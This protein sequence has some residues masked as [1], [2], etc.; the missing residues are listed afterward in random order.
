MK[1]TRK[2]KIIWHTAWVYIR[3]PNIFFYTCFKFLNIERER[4]GEK[5]KKGKREEKGEGKKKKKM[6]R[7]RRN[8]VWVSLGYVI[9][10][11]IVIQTNKQ[12]FLSRSNLDR[13]CKKLCYCWAQKPSDPIQ[14]GQAIPK[15][16]ISLSETWKNTSENKYAS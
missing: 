11:L 14:S 7:C 15:D 1:Q 16:S 3:H 13:E 8:L 10:I 5:G 6:E 4:E 2:Q 12:S 9:K